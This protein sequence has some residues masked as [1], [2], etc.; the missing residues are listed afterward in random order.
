MEVK[1]MVVSLLMVA[2]ASDQND[3]ATPKD[4]NSPL[5]SPPNRSLF[6]GPGSAN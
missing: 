2:A 3:S 4:T 6:F 5:V 1:A